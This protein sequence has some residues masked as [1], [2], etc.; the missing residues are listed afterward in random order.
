MDGDGERNGNGAGLGD[1]LRR[2]RLAVD[3]HQL[4]REL[5][6]QGELAPEVVLSQAAL[7]RQ[8]GISRGPVREAFRQLQEEGLITAEPDQRPRVAG[9]D[10]ISLDS[11][12]GARI[13][14][15]TLGASL[16][17]RSRTPE[18]LERMHRL[19]EQ[20]DEGVETY[21]LDWRRA[22]REFHAAVASGAGP[23]A[24]ALTVSLAER[25]EVYFRLYGQGHSVAHGDHRKVLAAIEAGDARATE[26]LHARHVSRTALTV[27]ANM[28][29]AYEP[30][31]IRASLRIFDVGDT[32]GE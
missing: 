25:S 12:Y 32:A 13:T 22:H 6:V 19:V 3:A 11:L 5:I 18:L 8:L 10:P 29:P 17:S 23:I 21:D 30:R 20:M 1:Q 2:R 31:V 15:E 14:L 26:V 27:L 7:A 4:L 9:F 24:S 16:V 28:A